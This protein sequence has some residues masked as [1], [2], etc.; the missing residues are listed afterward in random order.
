MGL[1]SVCDDTDGSEISQGLCAALPHLVNLKRF[2]LRHIYIGD[3]MTE[4]MNSINAPN[5]KVICLSGSHLSGCGRALVNCLTKLPFLKYLNLNSCKMSANETEEVVCSLP[6]SCPFL[7]SILL[8]GSD[9]STTKLDVVVQ[10]LPKLKILNI[11]KCIM[12]N[13]EIL[14]TAENAPLG[15]RILAI[16]NILGG[17]GVLEEAALYSVI[18]ERHSLMYLCVSEDQISPDGRKKLAAVLAPRLGHL[19]T[20]GHNSPWWKNYIIYYNSIAAACMEDLI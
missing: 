14:K 16:S 6:K 4:V 15:L 19:M 8:Q 12:D 5:L 20:E 2:D 1:S 9:L 18:K 11:S 13:K 17:K 7:V 10:Q 3:K